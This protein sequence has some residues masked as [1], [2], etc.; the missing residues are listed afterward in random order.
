M[1]TF[2][3]LRCGDRMAG[4]KKKSNA[5]RPT[6]MDEA[7]IH[8]LEEA[9]ALGCTDLEACYFADIS[10]SCLYNYQNSHPEFV[11]RKEKL[12][13]RPVLLARKA[14]VNAI[15]SGEMPGNKIAFDYLTK[16]KRDE[17]A[18]RVE[19]TGKDGGPQEFALTNFPKEPQ[20]IAE[21]EAQ[22]KEADDARGGEEV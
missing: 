8:K 15:L 14:V 22:I 12:K 20:S 11:E 7:T 2:L 13:E 18:D 9:F 17:F 10:K 21:W 4:R 3:V 6:I 16:R 1:D 19:S 5:G